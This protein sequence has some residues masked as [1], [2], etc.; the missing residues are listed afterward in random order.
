MATKKGMVR[1]GRA[2][3]MIP[4]TRQKRSGNALSEEEGREEGVLMGYYKVL[5][6]G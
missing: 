4:T 3:E 2:M 6:V 1:E 5:E